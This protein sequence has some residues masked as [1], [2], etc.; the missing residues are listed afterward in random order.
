M[1]YLRKITENSGAMILLKAITR[2]G[3]VLCF[4]ILPFS[5]SH[6]AFAT[7]MYKWVDKDGN[8]Q[9]TQ[10]PP[11]ADVEFSTLKPPPKVNSESSQKALEQR[12]EKLDELRE[13]RHKTAAEKKTTKEEENRLKKNCETAK[14][15]M[16]S[17]ARPRVTITQKDGTVTRATEEERQRRIAEA[18]ERIAEF[19]K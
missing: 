1:T 13:Q 12:T 9:Y 17:Y 3:V 2:Q 16:A 7:S 8:T 14:A 5:M 10:S 6:I 18:K 4:F 19:C 11:P 15:N